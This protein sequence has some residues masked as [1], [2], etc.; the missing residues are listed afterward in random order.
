MRFLPGTP[1]ALGL[2][3][4]L[5]ATAMAGSAAAQPVA[6]TARAPQAADEGGK[7]PAGAEA[8]ATPL[9]GSLGV[10][11]GERL[12]SSSDP[13]ARLRG[14]ERLGAIGTEEAV[15]ALL[16]A[17]EQHGAPGARDPRARLAAVRALAPHAQRDSV[18]QLLA[19]EL[20]ESAP[21]RGAASPLGEVLRGTAALALARTGERRALGV[22]VNAI[23]QGGAAGE[24]AARALKAHPPASLQLL[25]GS[26]KR[27]E[28]ALASFLGDLGDLRAIAALR[29]MLEGG[30]RAAQVAA[31]RALARLGDEAALAKARAWLRK[32][33]PGLFEPTA[34]ILVYL[35][36]PEA[37]DAVAALLGSELG[38]MEGLRL[39][40]LAPA[41]RLVPALARS[42]P[43]LP[44]DARPRAV[45][46]IGRAGGTEAARQLRRLPSERPE[47]ATA[48]AFALATMPGAEARAA[49]AELFD[50]P[51]AAKDADL[52]RLGL[53]AG[54]VRGL[55]LRDA[56]EAL[57]KRLLA[58]LAAPKGSSDRAVGVFGAVAL[59]LRDAVDVV[60]A[61]SPSSCDRA[62]VHAAAR[63]A[64]AR[65]E[66][67]LA[68]LA[69]L[70]AAL[71]ASPPGAA[72]AAQSG[73][74]APD[75]AAISA[76][77]ALLAEPGGGAIATS[78]LA[79]LAEAGGPL[80]PLAARALA[81]RDDEVVRG[82]IER[83]LEGSD[84]VVRAHVAL[85]LGS[86]PM[87]DSVSLLARA[88]RFEDDPAVRR[89]IVRGLSRRAEVQRRRVL[90]AARDLDPDEG[91][92]ALARA[93]LS[94][95]DARAL[96][97]PRS[98][99]ATGV[100]WVAIVPNDRSASMSASSRPARLVRPDGLAVP[101]VA[102]PDGV[103]LVP[104]VPPGASAVLLAPAA[105]PGDPGS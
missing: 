55:A 5:A 20:S 79:A 16:A 27:I 7:A 1:R 57:E 69:P 67:A 97:R 53:R 101:V 71:A 38:R 64:L 39:A 17:L 26:R 52:R 22:L 37:P 21:A 62:A 47:L 74:A 72:S 41:E 23:V 13:A 76:G 10:P 99:L 19:R 103:L 61:C 66:R 87:P 45:A 59:G 18:R 4:A 91:V 48:A 75:A 44:D 51:R 54:V 81:A 35:G 49:V 102:D 98:A 24:A 89:A 36:A 29:P 2:A 104:A 50:G 80:S 73:D 31:A 3:A 15:S 12:L 86:D 46:A 94:G 84:P 30:D 85:G 42:L 11:V 83:L 43:L 96:D 40:E 82:R 8:G 70:F 60:G 25:L 9:R 34:E 33:E 68:A 88:Y 32:P 105:P 56:P 65:G 78:R 14:I 6:R 63:G 100:V 93:A 77:V 58:A 28:P 95:V 92:R 90:V